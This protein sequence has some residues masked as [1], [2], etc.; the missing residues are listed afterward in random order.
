MCLNERD[1]DTL[2]LSYLEVEGW[3]GICGCDARYTINVSAQ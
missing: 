2:G 3:N 1:L